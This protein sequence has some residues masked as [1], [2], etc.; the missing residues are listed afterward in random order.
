MDAAD[1]H[2][3][4]KPIEIGNCCALRRF[5]EA[6]PGKYCSKCY[7]TKAAFFAADAASPKWSAFQGQCHRLVYACSAWL[8]AHRVFCSGP[9][10]GLQ[11]HTEC[12]FQIYMSLVGFVDARVGTRSGHRKSSKRFVA[13]E[14]SIVNANVPD[15]HAP[16]VPE[17]HA[18]SEPS[19][20]MRSKMRE[21]GE[22][23]TRKKDPQIP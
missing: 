22:T 13:V 18:K 7:D 20:A 8:G 14:R 10:V 2:S 15:K 19:N 3:G 12:K 4:N 9:F 17:T 1:P 6:I 16:T 23:R 21:R 5:L 11:S